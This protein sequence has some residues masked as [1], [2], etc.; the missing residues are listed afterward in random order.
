ML[1][2]GFIVSTPRS[3]TNNSP[4]S[5]GKGTYSKDGRWLEPE[6]GD[7][8][9]R[10]AEVEFGGPPFFLKLFF[11]GFVAFLSADCEVFE[12]IEGA[13]GAFGCRFDGEGFYLVEAEGLGEEVVNFLNGEW[14]GGGF[15]VVA[16][17][18]APFDE[19]GEGVGC[20]GGG[21]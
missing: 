18:L 19:S 7:V 11:G 21:K 10:V 13:W 4:A 3:R 16:G 5:A 6:G 15:Y 20:L 2:Q 8:S 9:A 17:H 12:V 1:E 14:F